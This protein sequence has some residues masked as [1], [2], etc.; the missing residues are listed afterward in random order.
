LTPLAQIAN[1]R[2]RVDA[3]RQAVDAIRPIVGRFVETLSD[4]QR[5]R[6][7]QVVSSSSA[8]AAR[9]RE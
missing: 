6:L 2:I 7:G 3:L 1:G 5:T 9:T 4:E 8:R